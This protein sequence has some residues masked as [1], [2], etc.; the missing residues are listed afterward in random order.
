[1]NELFNKNRV[2]KIEKKT[3]IGKIY[4]KWEFRA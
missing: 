1:M 4:G 3:G 2:W